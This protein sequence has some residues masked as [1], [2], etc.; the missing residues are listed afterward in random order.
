[1]NSTHPVLIVCTP[2]FL[3]IPK[4][5]IGTVILEHENS[6]AYKM[7]MKTHIDLRVFVEIYASKI[8]ARFIMADEMLRYET[9]GRKDIDS[10]NTLHPLS[11]RIDF[12]RQIEI[13]NPRTPLLKSPQ[14]NALKFEIFPEQTIKEIKFALENK[15]SVFIFSLRKGLA[16]TTICKDCGETVSCEKCKAPL[17][18]YTS[19]QGKKRMFVCN[20]C[21]QEIDGDVSCISCRSWNLMPLGIGTDTVLEEIEK[22]ILGSKEKIRIFKLDK[23]SAKTASGAKKIIKEFEENPGSILIGT[24]MAFFYLKKKV[25]LSIIASFDSLWS[26][27]NFKMGEKII[28]IILSMIGNTADKLII[29]TKNENDKA[30]LGIKSLNLLSF[31]REELEDRKKLNYPPYKRFIKI[32]Y[33]G[34]KEQTI[35]AKKILEEI[36]KDYSPE[37]FSG[38][39]AK[40]KNKYVTNV[41]IKIDIGKW[42]LPEIS[43]NSSIDQNLLTKLLSL[44]P[45]FQVLVDPEDLL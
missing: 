38:F 33:L 16:T 26:I 10:L 12:G 17:V 18:L 45:S 14:G 23:E 34:D 25:S 43:L 3:S 7:M 9:I 13:K 4:K 32:I 27:P 24:E 22:K 36:F 39:I 37:I 11:F 6:N 29:H 15:K 21:A 20:K 2:P 31:V 30:I 1:M 44:P 40:T 8:N 35:K 5:N 28:Q 41:L 19:H 42:S